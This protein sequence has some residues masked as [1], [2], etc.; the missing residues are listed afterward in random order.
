MKLLV[1]V[2]VGLAKTLTVPSGCLKCPVRGRVTIC[3][4]PCSSQ[5]VGQ[6][7]PLSTVKGKPL[8]QRAKPESCQPP[9]IASEMPEALSAKCLPLPNGNSTIQLAL[10]WW[11]VSKSET[12]R[13][14]LGS[15]AFTR[16]VPGAPTLQH[17]AQLRRVA[18]EVMSIDLE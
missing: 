15:K 11:V 1:N 16:R 9:M 2:A 14:P 7:F 18:E 12:P 10:I 13:R 8:V 3:A 17:D 4:I 5:L 6:K